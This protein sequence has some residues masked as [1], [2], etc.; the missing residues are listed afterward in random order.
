M[1][2]DPPEVVAEPDKREVDPVVIPVITVRDLPKGLLVETPGH[3]PN[4]LIEAVHPLFYLIGVAGKTFFTTF[5]AFWGATP[6]VAHI[7]GGTV[8]MG[9]IHQSIEMAA[10]LAL[11]PTITA[12]AT[13]L[14][15][16]FTKLSQ[17]FPTFG[18]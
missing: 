10:L 16:L 13:A 6:L 18:A 5:V 1:A 9:D 4:Y 15:L 3:T 8:A 2:L 14:G 7:T 12:V 17:K 11:I